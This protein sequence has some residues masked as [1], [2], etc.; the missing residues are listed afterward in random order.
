MTIAIQVSSVTRR[1]GSKAAVDNVSL[2]IPKGQCFGLIG[3][4]GAGKTTLFSMVCGH[5][6]PTQGV[7]RVMGKNPTQPGSLKGLVGCLPQD[8]VLPARWRVGELLTYW[9]QLSG[10]INPRAEAERALDMVGLK[11]TWAV[12][13][14]T[15]SH[16]MAKRVS[17]A[18]ALMGTPPVVCLDE[19]TS[20]L[21]PR[22]A[23]HVRDI[24]REIKGKQTLILS[25]HN[26]AELEEL[27]DATAILN[28]GR[29]VV[30]ASVAEL[31]AINDE[32]HITIARG[33]VP[34]QSVRALEGVVDARLE[35][36]TLRVFFD[37][38]QKA[39]EVMITQTLQ[40]LLATHVLVLEVN[41]GQKLEARVLQLT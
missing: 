11:E 1:F 19:P 33:E 32:F 36:N 9:A 12:H 28:Q 38:S 10:L 23:A 24:I 3:P 16:G 25:S 26:I 34:L 18:Q 20:G 40:C 37:G 13:A 35:G 2:A 22:N 41:R 14:G 39:P 7:V 8:A 27:C 15:L 5:V 17:L 21:D 4:N 6:R 31:K 30:S 29:L